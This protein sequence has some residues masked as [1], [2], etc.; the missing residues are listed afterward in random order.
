MGLIV[1]RDKPPPA[2][3]SPPLNKASVELWLLKY[4]DLPYQV[5]SCDPESDKISIVDGVT[6]AHGQVFIRPLPEDE[7][8][9]IDEDGVVFA[10][11]RNVTSVDSSFQT[12]PG[13]TSKLLLSGSR[14]VGGILTTARGMT[15]LDLF[16]LEE[17]EESDDESD[18][19]EV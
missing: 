7:G 8:E 11:A 12:A 1:A 14:G 9:A 13:S 10:R 17:D 6:S 15:Q 4:D 16:D 5:V 2:G 19:M 18:A 3:S